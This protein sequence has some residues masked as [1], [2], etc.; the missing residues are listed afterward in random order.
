MALLDERHIV[1][2]EAIR[3]L[4]AKSRSARATLAFDVPE[5][6]FY[7]GVEAAA[8]DNLHPERAG[9]KPAGWLERESV[10]FREGYL[11]ASGMISTAAAFDE[12]PGSFP[13]PEYPL[14]A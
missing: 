10:P 4:A 13:L 2:R 12:P 1:L 8:Q 5:W 9:A 7:L 11:T 6:S 3:G 14:A